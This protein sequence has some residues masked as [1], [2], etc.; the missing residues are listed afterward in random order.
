MKPL[1]LRILQL[2][3]LVMFGM[4][5]C[6]QADA[7]K[8]FDDKGRVHYGDRAPSGS[9]AELLDLPDAPPEVAQDALMGIDGAERMQRRQR[10][11]ETLSA[12][13]KERESLRKKN[14]EEKAKKLSDCE[15]MK[16]RVG[17]LDSINRFYQRNEKGE[18]VYMT[19]KERSS[20]VG[21]VKQKYKEKCE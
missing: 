9:K 15:K 18:R 12:E 6:S 14:A 4:P 19:D 21:E 11:T 7:Y 17:E 2:L 13:R 16:I 5:L 20:Y 10:I 3:V 8:W 1:G